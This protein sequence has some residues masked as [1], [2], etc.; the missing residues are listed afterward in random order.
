MILPDLL[1]AVGILLGLFGFAGAIAY[2]MLS[3]ERGEES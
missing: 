3:F 2:I 1:F